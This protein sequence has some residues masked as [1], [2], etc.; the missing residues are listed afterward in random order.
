MITTT[1]NY[2]TYVSN[3]TATAY[4]FSFPFTQPTDI[5]VFLYDLNL[6]KT[7]L[8]YGTDYTVAPTYAS[9]DSFN[10]VGLPIGGTVNLTVA[11][12]L[13]YQ[14]LIMRDTPY[15]QLTSYPE[16]SPFPAA[17]HE[18]ALDKLTILTQQLESALSRVAQTD[19]VSGSNIGYQISET[20]AANTIPVAGVS[21][22]LALGW[23]PTG[24][25]A[26]T[27]N[28]YSS[29]TTPAANTI[30]V[31]GSNGQLSAL[32]IPATAIPTAT[33]TSQGIVQPD[34][35]TI[36]ISN[37]VIS[38]VDSGNTAN[39]AIFTS[40]N[41]WTVP[42]GITTIY[43]SGCAGG[44]GGAGGNNGSSGSSGGTTTLV[45]GGTTLLSLAA[46]GGGGGGGS[47]GGGGSGYPTGGYGISG[48]NGISNYYYGGTGASSIFGSGGN[49]TSGAG[50]SAFGYGAGGG[51]GGGSATYTGG[52]GGAGQ[53]VL[54][55]AVTVTP[56]SSLT[57]T[58]G[59]GG[60][61][62]SG[63]YPGGNGAPGIL[64]I[65]W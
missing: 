34:N 19:P 6:N 63:T 46:G 8:N 28:N 38:A 45:S 42:N 54:L 3:G 25:N 29:S 49:N 61:G 20:P 44:G 37:G 27:L 2:V 41:S 62:G 13:N 18:M 4:I 50:I 26:S 15:T 65:Q 1:I 32:W 47:A 40:N 35:I 60:A 23:L 5:Q 33:A 52:G 43:V 64:I 36:T 7:Q 31:A 16:N 56:G 57:I 58:I 21:G 51:G 11:A 39:T 12:T 17:S 53:S 55:Q 30:P 48:Y 59:A 14:I 22:Q 10:P 9:G 24:I